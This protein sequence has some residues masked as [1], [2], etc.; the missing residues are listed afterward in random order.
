MVFHAPSPRNVTPD[1]AR[2]I[3]A[4]LPPFVAAVGLFVDAPA[5]TVLA[6]ARAL[7]L[8]HVQL[9]GQETPELVRV[10]APLT[11]I[12]AVRVERDRFA[13]T[14]DG[15]RRATRDLRL[16]HLAGLVLE[17]PNTA[18]PG[19]TGVPNDWAAVVD[20]QRAGA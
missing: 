1:R 11:V 18:A 20:A 5:E 13:Q 2:E 7:G 6:A 16:T 19:G 9:H 4:A 12:K 8:R 3:L 14:L 17:T 15:W 10:L